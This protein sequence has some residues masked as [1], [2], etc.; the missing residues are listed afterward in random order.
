MEKYF[1]VLEEP[2][3]T[4]WTMTIT[5]NVFRS[6]KINLIFDNKRIFYI[7]SYL[8]IFGLF[9]AW[10]AGYDFTINH[11][12]HKYASEKTD[13][14]AL[15]YFLSLSKCETVDDY[16]SVGHCLEQLMNIFHK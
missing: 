6:L 11:Q 1:Y 16:K 8:L 5:A 10:T 15:T 7:I 12:R 14:N 9:D 2:K 4:F 3:L 13:R